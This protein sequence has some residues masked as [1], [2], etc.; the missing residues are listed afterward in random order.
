MSFIDAMQ[1]MRAP[2]ILSNWLSVLRL[3]PSL[4]IEIGL[5]RRVYYETTSFEEFADETMLRLERFGGARRPLSEDRRE[6]NQRNL[7]T[8]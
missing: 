1:R 4:K 7:E 3:G 8:F 5:D 2:A 6:E